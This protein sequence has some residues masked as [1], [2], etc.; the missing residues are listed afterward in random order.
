MADLGN[1][2]HLVAPVSVEVYG[3]GARL[4]VI[5]DYSHVAG[6]TTVDGAPTANLQVLVFS[7]GGAL[8]GRTRSGSSGAFAVPLWHTGPV[9]VV[10]Q[11]PERNA[12]VMDHITPV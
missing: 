4:G 12:L 5:A 7:R 1:V 9:M 10:S 8:I 11:H 3:Y 6:T 2:G